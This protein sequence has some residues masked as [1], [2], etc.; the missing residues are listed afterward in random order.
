MFAF[1]R[2]HGAEFRRS[3]PEVVALSAGKRLRGG[4]VKSRSGLVLVAGVARKLEAPKRFLPTHVALQSSKRETLLIPVDVVAK[5][6]GRLLSAAA[7]YAKPDTKKHVNGCVAARVRLGD[8][9]SWLTA[10]H[11]ANSTATT[12]RLKASTT[13]GPRPYGESARVIGRSSATG[14]S[15][16]LRDAARPFRMD[17]ALVPEDD[18]SGVDSDWWAS[19]FDRALASDEWGTQVR[20]YL[21]DQRGDERPLQFVQMQGDGLH[22]FP[23]WKGR[24]EKFPRFAHFKG[25]IAA[26]DSGAPVVRRSGGRRVFVGLAFG[27]I[28]IGGVSGPAVWPYED[29]KEAF[30]AESSL[31]FRLAPL[32]SE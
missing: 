23:V 15:W 22:E 5:S 13:C 11:V 31:S 16:P 12:L 10:A 7:V 21:V 18:A 24:Y 14:W 17:V 9:V 29:I 26:G 8:E 3:F 27:S 30:E 4:A 2:R 32:E 1:I 20:Y 25:S 28:R 6:R 19:S